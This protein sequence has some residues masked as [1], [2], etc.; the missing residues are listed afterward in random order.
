MSSPSFE[1]VHVGL[2][3]GGIS[4]SVPCPAGT[5]TAA[6]IIT[7]IFI[8]TGIAITE[9]V[10][11]AAEGMTATTM[12]AAAGG[13][14][15]ARGGGIDSSSTIGVAVA[16]LSRGTLG[17][18]LTAHF[19]AV[20]LTH[21]PLPKRADTADN[22]DVVLVMRITMSATHGITAMSNVVDH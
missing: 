12:S 11:E 8:G 10:R 22:S 2:G 9:R 21:V 20:P 13:G 1:L 7:N 19:P 18:A 3:A 14:R 4:A 17:L 5:V 15:E 16:K 6:F